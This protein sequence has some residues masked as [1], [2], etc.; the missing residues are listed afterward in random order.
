MNGKAAGVGG[1]DGTRLAEFRDT[2]KELAL[3]F[4]TFG[5]DFD[6]PIGFGDAGEIVFEIADGDF[7]G[8]SRG[9]KRG[10]AGFFGGFET[11]ADDFV[12][13]GE[14]GAGL[15]VGRDDVE[16]DAR[17]TGIGEMRGDASA[18]GAGTEDD[19]F[20]DRTSHEGPSCSYVC[21]RTGYK[22][23]IAGSNGGHGSRD[24]IR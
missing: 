11:S 19:C 4:E 1:D 2:G 14:R 18:H 5:D 9:E 6:N 20:L 21:E 13:I 10:G 24:G 12:A 15:E 3:D 8:E 7:F 22:T 16:E 23:S 17:K